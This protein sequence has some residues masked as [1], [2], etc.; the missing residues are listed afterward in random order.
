MAVAVQ[1]HGL[2]NFYETFFTTTDCRKMQI[3]LETNLP[4]EVLLAEQVRISRVT[5]LRQLLLTVGAFQA[6]GVPCLNARTK[7]MKF[8]V[9]FWGFF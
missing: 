4:I 1:P 3:T 8:M 9:M 2:W 7:H 5:A 6:L